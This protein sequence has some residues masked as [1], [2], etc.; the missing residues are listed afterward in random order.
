MRE[1]GP[2]QNTS[3]STVAA[4]PA[5]AVT[6]SHLLLPRTVTWPKRRKCMCERH[7]SAPSCRRSLSKRAEESHGE[8]LKK[9]RARERERQNISC[10][11]REI[12]ARAM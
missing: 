4:T 5:T 7:G 8:E 9:S 1:I 6:S 11:E 10:G 2:A 3:S 12:Q